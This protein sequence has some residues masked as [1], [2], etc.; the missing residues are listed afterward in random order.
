MNYDP[1]SRKEFLL[2]N[3]AGWELDLD[4]L[5]PAPPINLEERLLLE[6]ADNI[7]NGSDS[8]LGVPFLFVNFTYNGDVPVPSVSYSDYKEWFYNNPSGIAFA[9][10]NGEIA[11]I[12]GVDSATIKYASPQYYGIV[13]ESFLWDDNGITPG[14]SYVIMNGND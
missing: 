14:Y 9:R 3:I 10:I 11:R 4:T 6:I 5:T 8:G 12:E 1:T 13:C 7:N 2:A